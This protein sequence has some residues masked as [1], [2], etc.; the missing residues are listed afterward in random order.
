MTGGFSYRFNDIIPAM[1]PTVDRAAIAG[2]HA[3][4]T[5]TTMGLVRHTF[6]TFLRYFGKHNPNTVRLHDDT[7][8]YREQGRRVFHEMSLVPVSVGKTVDNDVWFEPKSNLIIKKRRVP[9]KRSKINEFDLEAIGIATDL[10][11]IAPETVIDSAGDIRVSPRADF[12]LEQVV[13]KLNQDDFSPAG[14]KKFKTFSRKS[15]AKA[16]QKLRKNSLEVMEMTNSTSIREVIRKLNLIKP[17]RKI[18]RESNLVHTDGHLGQIAFFDNFDGGQ[19][20]FI[21]PGGLTI[22]AQKAFQRE[23]FVRDIPESE[24]KRVDDAIQA[25]KTMLL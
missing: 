7:L 3:N 4:S 20:M 13:A 16:M 24:V 17:M 23:E 22:G 25:L 11:L 21:D 12:T 19:L 6:S 8:T 14:T 18:M 10:N 15:P 1:A 5:S 2:V 9:L